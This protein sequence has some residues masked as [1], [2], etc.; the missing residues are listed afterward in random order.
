MLP[1]R[2]PNRH[3]R[4]RQTRRPDHGGREPARRHHQP[5]TGPPGHPRRYLVQ[6]SFGALTQRH[7][8]RQKLSRSYQER[9]MS[10]TV[11]SQAEIESN[12]REACEIEGPWAF[13]ERMSTLVRLS[14]SD[15]ERAAIDELTAK[16]DQYGV[17]YQLHTPT[18]FV[19]WPLGATLRALGDS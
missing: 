11:S 2:V 15:D 13:V 18:L 19:S 1:D 16:L 8:I 4:E 9:T 14:G 3:P 6:R 7:A 5:R 12:I 17:P 10:T